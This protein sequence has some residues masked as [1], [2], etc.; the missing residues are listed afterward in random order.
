MIDN[1]FEKEDKE[2]FIG[3]IEYDIT[4]SPRDLTPGSIVDMIDSGIMEIPLFQR[5]YVWDMKKASKLIESIILGLPIPELFFYSEGDENTTYKIIDG[6]QRLL[7]IYFYIKGR[8]PKNSAARVKIS[9]QLNT[10]VDFNVL[11]ADNTLFQDFSL[12]LSKETDEIKSRY[13]KKKFV[14]LDKDTQIKFK[15]RRYLR[16]V[17][18]RQNK[19]EN[20]NS[21]MFEIFNRLNTGGSPL[22]PQ[23]VRASLY[24]CPFYQLLTDLND[25][26]E[27]R[28]ILNNTSKDLHC[29]DLELILRSFAI[30]MDF[31]SYVSKMTPFLN[32]FSE[33]SKK[34]TNEKIMYLG[35]LFHSFLNACSN[36]GEKAFFR[37]NR[38]SK[39]LFESVFVAVCEENFKSNTLVKAKIKR[40]S[41]ETLKNDEEFVN[42]LQSGVMSHDAIEIRKK[43]AKEIIITCED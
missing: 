28:K 15:L 35:Q 11:L 21:S 3:L 38:F 20:N 10:G 34:F 36:L 40:D 18:I 29:T 14:L 2:E 23:E 1:F 25:C 8:F 39:A 17:V 37:N 27:W 42:S 9:K 19:P 41:L 12:I 33:K 26:K 31:G 5:N 43:R 6:Q 7:S 32:G 4:C 16:T 22:T 24:F 30:L 13:H